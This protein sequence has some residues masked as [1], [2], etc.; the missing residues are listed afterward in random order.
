MLWFALYALALGAELVILMV[1]ERKIEDGARAEGQ[2]EPGRRAHA[3][4][5]LVR[6]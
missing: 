5:L 4:R 2:A 3:R 6:N 1:P